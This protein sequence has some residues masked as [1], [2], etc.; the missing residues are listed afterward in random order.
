[1][2]P[3]PPPAAGGEKPAGFGVGQDPPTGGSCRGQRAGLW[4]LP[5]LLLRRL[6]QSVR[7]PGLVTL[8][9]CPLPGS[10]PPVPP[11]QAS[12]HLR[13]IIV[14]AAT[15]GPAGAGVVSA[16]GELFEDVAGIAICHPNRQGW[17][18]RG[19]APR[20]GVPAHCP[21]SCHGLPALR[22]GPSS[23]P[24]PPPPGPGQAGGRPVV[25]GSCHPE[26]RIGRAAARPAPGFWAVQP[27]RA[28][29]SRRPCWD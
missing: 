10:L 27:P 26:Q 8:P 2:P 16:R 21:R 1:M 23:P 3:P 13:L 19:A 15:R 28:L 4:A 12:L 20:R 5:R 11:G 18:L 24:P 25:R 6:C 9:T 7:F 22:W 14:A 29:G 17:G